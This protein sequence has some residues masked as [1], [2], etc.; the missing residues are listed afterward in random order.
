MR[1]ATAAV[2][3]LAVVVVAACSGGSQDGIELD[4][5]PATTTTTASSATGATSATGGTGS[6]TTARSGP[7]SMPS[8]ADVTVTIDAGTPGAT[9]SPGILGVSSNLT[10]TELQQAGLTIN[11][12]GGNPSTR[13]NYDIGHAWNQAA[14]YEFRNTNYGDPG[15]DAA[16]N[17][18]QSNAAAGVE[19]R[20]A[21]P[22]LG[23]IAKSDDAND[24]SFP[25][26]GGCQPASEVGSCD[27]PK[28]EADPSRA[29]VE[30]TPD[31]VAAWLQ[32]MAAAGA[33]PQYVAMDNEPELW[34]HTHYDVH[35]TC[36]TYEEIL[37]KYQRYAAVVRNAM[38][39]A[40]LLGPVACCWYDY[41]NIAP[42]PQDGGDR[43]FLSWFLDG[44]K[45]SDDASGQRSIDYLDVHYYP[46]S[47]VFNDKDDA[48]T[49]AR[50]LRSTKS[51]WD[52]NYTDESWIATRIRFIP[53]LRETIAEHYPGLKLFI[54]EWNF[55]ND[56]NIN[57]ALAIADVLGIYGREGV[58][59]AA[60]WRNPPVGSPGWFAFTMH[61]NYD[62]KGSRFGG[63]AVPATTG[64]EDVGAYAAIDQGVMRVMLV[65]RSPEEAISVGLDITGFAAS[66]DAARY[67]YSPAHLDRIVA[68]TVAVDEPLTLPASS[69]TVLELAAR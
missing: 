48:E 32:R 67:V 52:P 56:A 1:R 44:L 21:I 17:Y 34:G 15:P 66:D 42:G 24:C 22:T 13:Y 35:P 38:P 47:D 20:M 51:L 8:A 33:A 62:G 65:N 29:N 3:V 28:V 59:A 31:K 39:D 26:D 36:P 69:I 53:R 41:W 6:S 9:I 63:T 25:K 37:D 58:E 10:A 18:V 45:R 54:S 5:I 40:A 55:G 23:W 57:G 46:Q 16:R 43:D 2:L 60:Y 12:W 61:G 64:N 68:D 27:D 30:S 19:T 50:R 4:S 7:T 11:S 49:N 14:D